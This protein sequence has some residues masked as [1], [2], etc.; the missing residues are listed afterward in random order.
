MGKVFGAVADEMLADKG[1]TYFGGDGCLL[2][3]FSGGS[4]ETGGDKLTVHKARS[5]PNSNKL[6]VM[7]TDDFVAF[8]GG[9]AG[10]KGGGEGGSFALY[11]DGELGMGTSCKTGTYANN[12]GVASSDEFM[13][14]ALEVWAFDINVGVGAKKASEA[15]AM[16]NFEI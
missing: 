11:L 13:I 1:S 14:V 5:G 12:A 16:S 10:K 4:S 3:E 6:F 7:A 8:G 9:G 15:A 2:F